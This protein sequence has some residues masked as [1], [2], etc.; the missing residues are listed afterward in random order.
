MCSLCVLAVSSLVQISGVTIPFILN[1]HLSFVELYLSL[2]RI[3]LF[4]IRRLIYMFYTGFVFYFSFI[5]YLLNIIFS[6]PDGY[7]YTLQASNTCTLSYILFILILI[8]LTPPLT[9]ISHL[10]IFRYYIILIHTSI[11]IF[12]QFLKSIHS[13]FSSLPPIP[14]PCMLLFLSLLPLRVYGYARIYNEFEVP[15]FFALPLPFFISFLA[16]VFFLSL[17]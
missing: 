9:R 11:F 5:F 12:S 15:S 13:C 8:I 2:S 4:L 14:F 17:L 1:G 7:T 16:F 3:P 6:S 10:R